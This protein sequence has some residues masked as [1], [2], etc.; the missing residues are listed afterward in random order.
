M[1]D[2]YWMK[3]WWTRSG[4]NRGPQRIKKPAL[5]Q[6]SYASSDWTHLV[7][8]GDPRFELGTLGLRI[9]CSNQLS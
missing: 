9:P 3:R 5:Y 4:S 6:L 2:L 1:Y 8:V 7:M